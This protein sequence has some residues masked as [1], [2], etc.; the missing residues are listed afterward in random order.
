MSTGALLISQDL[1]R[2][3]KKE[4]KPLRHK[5]VFI[6]THKILH[7]LWHCCTNWLFY[8]W[9]T[10]NHSLQRCGNRVFVAFPS[11]T[12]PF[13]SKTWSSSRRLPSQDSPQSTPTIPQRNTKFNLILVGFWLWKV[14]TRY[15]TT[16]QVVRSYY[17]FSVIGRHYRNGL[18]CW[19]YTE[20]PPLTLLTRWVKITEEGQNNL[21]H[22]MSSDCTQTWL[23]WPFHLLSVVSQ[24]PWT[25]LPAH[26][27]TTKTT[28]FTNF[29]TMKKYKSIP[30]WICPLPPHQKC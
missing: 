29:L 26:L 5:D 9:Y 20:L 4:R 28:G 19:P 15:Y 8:F 13:V 23:E 12:T 24:F 1:P 17:W 10:V 21:I 25:V 2:K 14:S 27:H 16:I 30:Y 11:L 18:K 6:A 7:F 3:K 22:T